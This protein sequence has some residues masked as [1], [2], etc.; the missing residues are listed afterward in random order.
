[1]ECERKVSLAVIDEDNF[2]LVMELEL[3]P[4][5]EYNLASNAYSIAQMSYYSNFIGHAI[6][7]NSKPVG[8]IMYAM[9]P[10]EDFTE[11]YA[12]Y[13]FMIDKNHQGKG[14]GSMALNMLI[15]KIKEENF[16]AKKVTICY[17]TDNN[18]LR[19][20]YKKFGFVEVG[21]DMSSCQDDNGDP[22]DSLAEIKLFPRSVLRDYV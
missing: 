10:D 1:M 18:G 12:I 19:S 5:Q 22:V 8:F 9:L 4:Y 2:E 11:E 15:S 17:H 13:R 3:E 16:S 7:L 20:F 21:Y 6:C 14:I